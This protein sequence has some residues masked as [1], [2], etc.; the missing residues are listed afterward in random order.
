[1]GRYTTN[2][3][4]ERAGVSIGSLYQYFPNKEAVTAEL[5]RRSTL[6]LIDDVSTASRLQDWRIAIVGMAEAAVRHQLQ[7]PRL[8]A[9]LDSQQQR[10]EGAHGNVRIASTILSAIEHV[11]TLAKPRLP[12]KPFIMASD[13]FSITRALTDSAA[14]AGERDASSLRS[15]ICRAVFR[16]IRVEESEIADWDRGLAAATPSRP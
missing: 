11:L 7:R 3:V 5:W 2:A 1:M 4:A 10:F 8:A 16:H 14:I 6:S 15:R 9:L 13:L 12:H